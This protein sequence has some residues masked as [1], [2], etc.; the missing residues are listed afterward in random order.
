LEGVVMMSCDHALDRTAFAGAYNGKRVLVTGHTGFKGSWLCEW[1][2]GLGAN[3]AG[4][5]LSPDATPSLFEQLELADR[6]DHTIADIRDPASILALVE[7]FRPDYLFHFAAQP[8]VRR[9]YREPLLTW[10]TNVIGTANVLEALR[11]V[12]WPCA[13]VLV[14]T[15][16]CYENREWPHGYRETDALGGHDP[17]SS[18]KAAAEVAIASWRRSFFSNG[19]PVR[20]A[21]TRAGNVIGGGD[22][23]E[24]RIVPDL[25]R[26]LLAKQAV[27]VRNPLATRPWQHVLEPLS[28]YLAI[29]AALRSEPR[30]HLLETAFNIGPDH[31]SNASVQCVVETALEFW[32]GAWDRVGEGGPHE[33]TFLHLDNSKIRSLLGWRPVLSLRESI[34]LTVEWYRDTNGHHSAEAISER[35]VRD[36]REFETAARHANVSW[37]TSSQPPVS[38][39]A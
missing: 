23:A 37:L 34:R 2:L 28:G 18:S 15:D 17:Y 6:L 35:T 1:L 3:V 12:D 13:A 30:Q 24:D 38:Q 14:T 36:I 7:R 5:A 4:L 20:L 16:K 11:R 29:A 21:S 8:L 26:A 39:N 9:S 33:A 31:D 19:H 10:Q 25:V 27:G 22:W 32:N